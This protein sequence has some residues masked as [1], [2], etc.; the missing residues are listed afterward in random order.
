ML[1]IDDVSWLWHHRIGG[2]TVFPCAGYIV[3]AGE[4]MRQIAGSDKYRLRNLRMSKALT[5][6][7]RGRIEVV[8]NFRP[9]RPTDEP[10]SGW[11]EFSISSFRMGSWVKHCTGQ[12]RSEAS[13]PT[14]RDIRGLPRSVTSHSWYEN[15]KERGIEYGPKFRLLQHITAHPTHLS[16]T[17][18]LERDGSS[19]TVDAPIIDQCLQLVAVAMSNGLSRKCDGVGMPVYIQEV[20]VGK[21]GPDMFLEANAAGTSLG[22]TSGFAWAQW[23]AEVGIKI[24]GVEFMGFDEGSP[25]DEDQKLCSNLMWGPDVDFLPKGCIFT[26][27]K[28]SMSTFDE[29]YAPRQQ[30]FDMCIIE[31]ARLIADLEPASEYLRKYQNWMATRSSEILRNIHSSL[32]SEDREFLQV[33]RDGWPNILSRL[34]WQIDETMPLS[35]HFAE[36]SLVV[37]ESCTDIVQGRCQPLGLL[38]ENERLSQLYNTGTSRNYEEFLRLLGHSQPDLQIIEIGAGTG[39]TTARA[40]H[41]LHPEGVVRQ[42]S[43]YVFTDISSAFFQPAM[44]RFKGYEGVEYAVLD[45]SQPPVDQEIQPASFDL[46]IA[47]NVSLLRLLR[48]AKIL[49]I[50]SGTSCNM[51]HTRDFEKCQFS[52]QTWGTSLDRRN[53]HW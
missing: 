33:P 5:L 1:H 27:S 26:P 40:L 44:E 36:L 25:G 19:D 30:F 51:Q 34:K 6:D 8:S 43:R 45:I 13:S 42:Y 12:V 28:P 9:A 32:S 11:Y 20:F 41:C 47:S 50:I 37:L 38:M 15:L 17:A 29:T 49:T 3:M 52:P 39:A 16:A 22:M 7:D 35:K 10:G 48:T 21:A 14:P 31:T 23:G 46:V 4:A 24:D 53:L 2:S 18:S